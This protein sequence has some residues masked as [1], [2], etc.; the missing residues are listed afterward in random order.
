VELELN[1]G[2]DGPLIVFHDH[3]GRTAILAA[4]LKVLNEK[5]GETACA[6]IDWKIRSN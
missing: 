1:G 6:V 3:P 5:S 4:A 2:N